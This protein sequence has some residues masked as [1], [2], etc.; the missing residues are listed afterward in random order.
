VVDNMVGGRGEREPSCCCFRVFFCF[1]LTAPLHRRHR[2]QQRHLVDTARHERTA[3][4]S[5]EEL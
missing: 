3:K 1:D 2:V 5:A 4:R